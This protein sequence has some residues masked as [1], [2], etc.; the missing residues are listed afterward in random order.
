MQILSTPPLVARLVSRFAKLR[1]DTVTPYARISSGA[2]SSC[3]Q[4]ARGSDHSQM[5]HKSDFVNTDIQEASLHHDLSTTPCG[6]LRHHNTQ[7]RTWRYQSFQ[8]T[9][10]RHDI[11]IYIYKIVNN[12]VT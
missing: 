2:A 10:P 8:G 11:Y 6:F 3:T 9:H 5:I 4:D 1:T 7:S 12:Y